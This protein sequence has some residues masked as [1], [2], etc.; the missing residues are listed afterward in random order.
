MTNVASNSG[1]PSGVGGK[2]TSALINALNVFDALIPH[3]RDAF[4]QAL[5]RKVAAEKAN[6]S[7][8]ELPTASA[9]N[10]SAALGLR[11]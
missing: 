5:V 6:K 9:S 1:L 3:S 2:D 10:P 11:R 4:Q 8:P 7:Q